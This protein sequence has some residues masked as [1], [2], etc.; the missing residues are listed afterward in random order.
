MAFMCY[1]RGSSRESG[2]WGVQPSV[3][4]VII[5]LKSY[6]TQRK[7]KAEERKTDNRAGEVQ[8]SEVTAR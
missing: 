5:G 1:I 4:P 3:H 2:R 6:I 7:G 8:E